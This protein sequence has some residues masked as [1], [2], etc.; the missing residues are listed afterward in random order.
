MFNLVCLRHLCKLI[1]VLRCTHN[2]DSHCQTHHIAT[3]TTFKDFHKIMGVTEPARFAPPPELDP[4][5]EKLFKK[6]TV[7][8]DKNNRLTKRFDDN[9]VGNYMTRR[10]KGQMLQWKHGIFGKT[11]KVVMY[12]AWVDEKTGEHVKFDG[13]P[14]EVDYKRDMPPPCTTIKPP[15][16]VH[17]FFIN[18][19]SLCTTYKKSPWSAQEVKQ[20]MEACDPNEAQKLIEIGVDEDKRMVPPDPD[21]FADWIT[22]CNEIRKHRRDDLVAYIA[23]HPELHPAYLSDQDSKMAFK[24][25]RQVFIDHVYRVMNSTKNHS[26]TY[27]KPGATHRRTI[28]DTVSQKSRRETVELIGE[29]WFDYNGQLTEYFLSQE[30]LKKSLDLIPIVAYDSSRIT[31]GEQRYLQSNGA[32]VVVD[33]TT[34]GVGTNKDVISLSHKCNCIYILTNGEYTGDTAHVIAD[35]EA[36]DVYND[37][38]EEEYVNDSDGGVPPGK[39]ARYSDGDDTN[40]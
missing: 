8:K 5:R 4:A 39:R 29:P 22:Y 25:G 28:R 27:T 14:M 9:K 16:P 20:N 34:Y 15:A 13:T 32:V 10:R 31:P 23:D 21:L 35:E 30:G 19:K 37:E 33:E 3:V 7:T 26:W 1:L 40:N 18:G 38:D 17:R 11:G 36:A 2:Q 24:Q 12:E 6:K